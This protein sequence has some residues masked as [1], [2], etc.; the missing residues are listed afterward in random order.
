MI[1][2][3]TG[4]MR[5]GKSTVC[6]ILREK[7]GF[8]IVGFADTLKEM[9]LAINPDILSTGN[10]DV[11][12]ADLVGWAGWEGAK[13]HEA[14]GPAVRR[15]LQRLGTDGV[16]KHLGADAWVDAWRDKVNAL[17][18]KLGV[19][20]LDVA[21]PDVRFPNEARMVRDCAGEVWRIE[22]P[23]FGPTT[24]HVSETGQIDVKADRVIANRYG[25]EGLEEMVETHLGDAG[26]YR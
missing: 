10:G 24:G 26:L 18:D 2:G 5:S 12:L 14:F 7:H 20:D 21:V 17:E 22:R 4:F 16:R 3:L 25:L 1:I 13:D 6:D 19:Q 23:G 15:F 11:P 8:H 9:A